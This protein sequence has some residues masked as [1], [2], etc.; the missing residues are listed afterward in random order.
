MPARSATAPAPAGASD[1]RRS[2]HGR[3]SLHGRRRGA[4]GGARGEHDLDAGVGVHVDAHPARA[5]GA[6]HGVG[7]LAHADQGRRGTVDVAQ[8]VTCVR[9][10][11]V[12]VSSEEGRA[13]TRVIIQRQID[14][15]KSIVR[16][17]PLCAPPTR[18]SSTACPSSRASTFRR[19]G[20]RPDVRAGAAQG[21]H[22]SAAGCSARGAWAPTARTTRWTCATRRPTA[23]RVAEGLEI[24][25]G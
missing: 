22:L 9:A 25:A 12:T 20:A 13:R 8:G 2:I 11:P 4:L 17:P 6:A 16:L 3:S 5:L 21:P 23:P 24:E 1:R 19:K 18:C 10:W 15:A 14:V 7:D